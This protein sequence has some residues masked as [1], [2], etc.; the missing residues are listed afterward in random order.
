MTSSMPLLQSI[1][2]ELDRELARLHALRSIVAS[3]RRTP[4]AVGQ[5]LVPVIP[6]AT[7]P[8]AEHP[9]PNRKTRVVAG[10]PRGVRVPKPTSEPRALA[11]NVPSGPVVVNPA[12]LAEERARRREDREVEAA[13]E[14]D[15][16]SQ[17]DLDAMSRS[18]AARWNTGAA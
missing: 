2:A 9:E 4:A 11:M 15:A 17:Q 7:T 13:S 16:S 12:R 3:L 8:L 6:P 1:L 5:H 18:L 10:R 14:A